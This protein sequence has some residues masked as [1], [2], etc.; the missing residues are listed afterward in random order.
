MAESLYLRVVAEA[1]RSRRSITTTLELL[2]LAGL[3]QRPGL[4][5][6]VAVAERDEAVQ[7]MPASNEEYA[8]DTR[9][10]QSPLSSRSQGAASSRSATVKAQDLAERP[11][12]PDFRSV[13]K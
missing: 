12:K 5:E 6:P 8:P 4:R 9:L 10:G 7:R 2:V 13:K 1:E 3:G 11:F